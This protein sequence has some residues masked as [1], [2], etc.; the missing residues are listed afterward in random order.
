MAITPKIKPSGVK[1]GGMKGMTPPAVPKEEDPGK[2]LGGLLGQ[3]S[4]LLTRA[5]ATGT[6][7]ANRRGLLNSSMAAQASE[8][9]AI[10]VAVP[11]VSQ[12][13]Q[14]NAAS[15]LSAQGFGQSRILQNDSI[16]SQERMQERDLGSRRDLTG[17]E[18][19]SREKLSASDIASRE[20]LTGMEIGSREKLTAQEL[21]SREGLAGREI[22]SQ[23]KRQA[24]QLATQRDL[25]GAEIA[26]RERLN[27][28]DQAAQSQRQQA[29]IASDTAEKALD[30][31]LQE[32]LANWNLDANERQGAATML[33][34]QQQWYAAELQS[35]QGNT[36]ISAKDRE[37]AVKDAQ[38]RNEKRISLVRQMYNVKVEW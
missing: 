16:D 23:E 15:N 31:D 1:L 9:A 19:E 22:A 6:Q 8:N 2:L 5:R 27:A 29:Q 18:I 11:L 38:A 26:S 35:I 4:A 36:A 17:M 32:Q 3:D 13:A 34:Q 25:T 10:D 14:Q 24:E 33:S 7:I 12:Q 30:R 21:A 37:I 28:S 20:K